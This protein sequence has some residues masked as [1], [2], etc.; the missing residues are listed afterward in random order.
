MD[1]LSAQFNSGPLSLEEIKTVLGSDFGSSWPALQKKFSQTNGKFFNERMEAEKEKRKKHSEKQS[2]NVKK[3]WNKYDGN[4]TVYTKP[5]PLENE[6]ENRNENELNELEIEDTKEF[7]ERLGLGRLKD[8]R[9]K[10]LFQAFLKVQDEYYPSRTKKIHHFMH[11]TK[12]ELQN[13]SRS[14]SKGSSTITRAEALK[15]F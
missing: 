15:D 8:E 3:R 4:T 11:L 5:I 14:F 9:I 1:I 12:K 7:F 6:N 13:E 10:N 2:E